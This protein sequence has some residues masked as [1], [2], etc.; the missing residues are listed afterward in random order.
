MLSHDWANGIC[1]LVGVVERNGGNVVVQN[2]SLDDAVEEVAADEAKFTVDGGGSTAGEV[3][4][5]GRVV[6]K[7]RIG[8]L[9]IGDGNCI[10]VLVAVANC[11]C[12]GTG[13]YLASGS[14]R[15]MGGSTTPADWSS[16]T[17]DRERKGQSR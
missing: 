11:V 7:R 10:I 3:P 12:S 13:A 2:V 4:G 14:P 1:G 15:G 17:S 5:F 8:V 16:R 6:R 9:K